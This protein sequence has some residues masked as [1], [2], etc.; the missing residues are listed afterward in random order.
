MALLLLNTDLHGQTV[1]RRMSCRDF[2]DNLSQ[3]SPHL[4]S[5]DLLKSL[6]NSIKGHPIELVREP[7]SSS[8]T[9][10]D[11]GL[12]SRSLQDHRFVTV[13]DPDTQVEYKKG[14]VLRKAV[15][16]VDGKRSKIF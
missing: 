15:F 10:T 3:N 9:T 11:S 13:P 6:Y 8:E 4:Y 16:D 14:W 12:P 2:I 5:R 1:G 7:G